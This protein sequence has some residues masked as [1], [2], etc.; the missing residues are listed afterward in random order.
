MSVDPPT[1][2]GT[3]HLVLSKF[4]RA[5]FEQGHRSPLVGWGNYTERGKEDIPH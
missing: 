4:V 5:L 1:H 3:T 2:D